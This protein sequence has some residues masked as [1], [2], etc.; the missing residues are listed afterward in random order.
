MSSARLNSAALKVEA[1]RMGFIACGV[2]R[3]HDIPEEVKA[4]Y[5]QWIARG[6]QAGMSYLERHEELRFNPSHLVPG[7]KTIVS[8]ALSYHPSHL[9]TQPALAWYAQGEDYHNVMRRLLRQ[10]MKAVGGSGRCFVDSAPVMERYWAQQAG[11]GFV[12]RHCQLVIPRIGS[13]F[14]LGELF[15]TEE[16]DEYDEPL[17]ESTGCGSCRK[18]LD[19]C[20]TKAITDEG[21]DASRCLSYLTIEHRGELPAEVHPLLSECFYGCDRCLRS[22]PHLH[23]PEQPLRSEFRPSPELLQMTT[24]DWQSLSEEHYEEL[25]AHS[26]VRRARFEGLKRNI[27]PLSAG[28]PRDTDE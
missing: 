14:F 20:P 5:R 13:A 28:T 10:L 9:P 6:R 24:A 15:L 2:A 3:A 26:A 1:R 11:I 7:V 18:C 4:R 17:P 25:F 23:A 12:G 21:M 8:L 16:A 19:A 27:P 22:C